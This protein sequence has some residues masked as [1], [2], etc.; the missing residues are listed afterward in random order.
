MQA[1]PSG[2]HSSREVAR[3]DALASRW[4]DP[5]GPM[6]PLHRMNP[7]RIGW[8]ERRMAPA[9]RLLDVGCGG[10]LAAEA[11][12][13]R[14]H[15]VLGID[16]AGEAIAVARAHAACLGLALDYRAATVDE[17]AAEGA[18]FQAITVLEVIEH[19]PDPAAFL[20]VLAG[21]LEPEGALF[22]S[23]LNRTSRSFLAA[24]V[25]AEY[26]LHWLPVGTHDWRR[27]ITPGEMGRLL[28]GAGLRVAD[29]TGLVFDP[30]TLSWSA[31][32][33]LG[34][35]YLLEARAAGR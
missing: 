2:G 5:G 31:G 16:V 21:L 24:K 32:R 27:F 15:R 19:V 26:L 8:I 18:R 7:V 9:S 17:V 25:G 11:L 10:G 13:R 28:R 29:I 23:T 12:A 6:A 3:F 1:A 33:D 4:W 35:N 34:V 30:F 22:L 20:G 14:G